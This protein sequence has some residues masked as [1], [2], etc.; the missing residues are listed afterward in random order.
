MLAVQL[1]LPEERECVSLYSLSTLEGIM[2]ILLQLLR[3]PVDDCQGDECQSD[4]RRCH[5]CSLQ[6]AANVAIG[7]LIP[8]SSCQQITY[9][10]TH[11]T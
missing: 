3:P 6:F 8:R 5:A 9:T 1:L 11:T 7:Q 2:S 10:H 4:E